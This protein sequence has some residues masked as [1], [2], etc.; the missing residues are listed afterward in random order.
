MI[1]NKKIFFVHIPRT[2]GRYVGYL[3]NKNGYLCYHN[4]NLIHFK[5][6]EIQ[7]LTYPEHDIYLLQ[8]PFKKFTI[9]REPIDRCISA[10]TSFAKINED[11]I[12]QIFKSQD[13]FDSFVNESRV[14]DETNWFVPQVHFIDYKTKIWRYENKLFSSFYKWLYKNFDIEIKDILLVGSM[15]GYN[16]SEHSDVDLHIVLDFGEISTDPELLRKYFFLAKSKWNRNYR[17]TVGGHDVEVYAE[18]IGDDPVP[19]PTYSLMRGEWILEPSKEDVSID[20]EGVVKKVKEKV[21]QI[22]ELQSLHDSGNYEEAYDL[23]LAMKTKLRN[24]RKS[25]LDESG[26]FSIENLAYKILRRS[27]E[28]E[29][30]ADILKKSYTSMREGDGI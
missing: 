24:F 16:Y 3:L 25:G 29:R 2:A 10:L 1:I 9:T 26:E 30:V 15:A 18:D 27:G 14:N 4:N 23:S 20:Y 11:K 17:V 8:N 21:K 28:I 6:K 22:D 7:H 12:E 5:E 19:S 13:S